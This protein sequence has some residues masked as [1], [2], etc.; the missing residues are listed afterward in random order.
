M[1]DRVVLEI[2][3][4]FWYNHEKKKLEKVEVPVWET[5]E[6]FLFVVMS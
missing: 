4:S 1:E 5:L 2:I 6:M 3:A